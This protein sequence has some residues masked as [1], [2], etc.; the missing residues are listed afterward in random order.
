LQGSLWQQ[1]LVRLE[2]EL[3]EQQFNT[4]IRPLHAVEEGQGLKLLAP[5]R[6]VLD[7]VKNNYITSIQNTVDTL[8]QDEDL[9]VELEIGSARSAEDRGVT[10]SAEPEP[11]LYL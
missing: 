7:W 3:P 6:F 1:C 9:V 11:G 2:T 8:C 10:P 4:W 5:N